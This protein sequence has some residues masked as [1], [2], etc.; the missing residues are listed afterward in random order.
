M[1]MRR[2]VMLGFAGLLA[3]GASAAEPSVRWRGFDLLDI[4]L[5]Y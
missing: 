4:L 2:L 3:L 5:R 1:A